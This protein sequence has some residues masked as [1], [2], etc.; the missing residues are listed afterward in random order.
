LFVLSLAPGGNRIVELLGS[1]S[2]ASRP[3]AAL[4]PS[5]EYGGKHDSLVH[6]LYTTKSDMS[7]IDDLLDALRTIR[8]YAHFAKR[9]SNTLHEAG[10]SLDQLAAVADEAIVEA[11]SMRRNRQL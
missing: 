4:E 3:P 2:I 11:R 10:E 1:A 7:I 9:V 6:E 5:R 8:D